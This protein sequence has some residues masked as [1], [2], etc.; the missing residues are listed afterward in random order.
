MDLAVWTV[1]A[2]RMKRRMAAPVKDGF[3][4]FRSAVSRRQCPCP[5]PACVLLNGVLEGAGQPRPGEAV[6]FR[7]LLPR[8]S[9]R[10]SFHF[11][12]WS[13]FSFPLTPAA[14]HAACGQTC[15]RETPMHCPNCGS[16]VYGGAVSACPTCGSALPDRQAFP[17]GHAAGPHE[18]TNYPLKSRT[19]R[20]G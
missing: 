14:R 6:A 4:G 5:A 12:D 7:Q 10:R 8:E 17:A 15:T 20:Y 1:P 19:S 3:L 16:T 9:L 11:L 2:A 13:N 18:T